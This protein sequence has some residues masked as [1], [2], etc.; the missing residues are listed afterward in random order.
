VTPVTPRAAISSPAFLTG[1]SDFRNVL[2][3]WF[4]SPLV[5]GTIMEL[6]TVKKSFRCPDKDGVKVG[7]QQHQEV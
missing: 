5:L 7:E 1:K 3:S 4:G 2:E 6:L